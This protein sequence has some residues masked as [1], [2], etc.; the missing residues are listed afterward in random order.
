MLILQKD[1]RTISRNPTQ[2]PQI[3][4][5]ETQFRVSCQNLVQVLQIGIQNIGCGF[6]LLW[7]QVLEFLRDLIEYVYFTGGQLI[8]KKIIRRNI[9]CLDDANECV[10]AGHFQPPLDLSQIYF[11]CSCLFSQNLT[12]I[13]LCQ[14][15]FPNSPSQIYLFRNDP[16]RDIINI[17]CSEAARR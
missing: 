15:S 14:S 11:A 5:Q 4:K 7:C 2:T 6:P 13:A 10:H 12:R 3:R 1:K 16:S 17:L 8:P 9:Q